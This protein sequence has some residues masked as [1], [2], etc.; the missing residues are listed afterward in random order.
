MH[1]LLER[2]ADVVIVARVSPTARKR[3]RRSRRTSP[4]SSSSTSACRWSRGSTSHAVASRST[5]PLVVF[6]TAYDSFALPA[7]ETD[8]VDYLTKP[9]T[10]ERFDAALDRVRERLRLRRQADQYE[11][12]ADASTPS[13]APHLVSRIGT[14]D[15]IIPLETIDYIEA[16]DVYAA[17]IARGQAATSFAR[18]SIRSSATLDPA[19]FAR[20]HRSYIVRLDRVTRDAPRPD[21]RAGRRAGR[22]RRAAGE[23][24]SARRSR[25]AAQATRDIERTA[26]DSAFVAAPRAMMAKRCLLTHAHL[27]HCSL[28]AVGTSRPVADRLRARSSTAPSPPCSA[29]TSLA[30]ISCASTRRHSARVRRSAT[31]NAPRDRGASAYS[32]FTELRDLDAPRAA[33]HGAGRC[34]RPATRA[35]DRVTILTDSVVAF[36]LRGRQSGT[37]HAFFEDMHRPHR[38]LA[39]SRAAHSPRRRRSSRTTVSVQALRADATTSCRFHGATAACASS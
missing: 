29:P 33:A 5:G 4:T 21:E 22:W 38:R 39:G 11:A 27:S 35:P 23:S 7:F 3:A 20:I 31:P 37:S 26:G 36:A 32:Q 17:V 18:R 28:L 14:R 34:R 15:V 6:V 1:Q 12:M 2:H 24:A 19:V 9:L 25:C 8:A 13:I 16:D 10:E 30:I